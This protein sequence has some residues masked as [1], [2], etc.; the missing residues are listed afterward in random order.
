MADSLQDQLRALGLAKEKQARGP[1]RKPQQR[2]ASRRAAADPEALSL[3]QAYALKEREE[4]RQAD[5][6]RKR[7]LAEERKRRELNQRIRTIV[8]QYRQNRD[9]AEIARNF[10]YKGRIRKIHV[11]PEQQTALNDGEMGIVYLSGGYHLVASEQV[12]A[13]RQ[14]SPEHVPDLAGTDED[15]GDFPVPD[16]LTW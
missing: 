4:Q 3:E 8:E 5:Q 9:D 7:Q 12:E 10:L 2:R 14:L 6:A 15:D 11:T 16:D 13:V 1:K